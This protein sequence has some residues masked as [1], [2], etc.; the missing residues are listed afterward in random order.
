MSL[1]CPLVSVS[2]PYTGDMFC[3]QHDR[4]RDEISDQVTKIAGPVCKGRNR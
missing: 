2:G 1:A 3:D 4:Q